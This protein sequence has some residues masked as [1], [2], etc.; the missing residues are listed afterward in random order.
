MDGFQHLSMTLLYKVTHFV[1]FI[2]HLIY[3][4]YF[5]CP[6]FILLIHTFSNLNIT[7]V[8]TFFLLDLIGL[9]NPPILISVNPESSNL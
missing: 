5:K 3:C 7:N 2:F 4:R 1:S 6:C 8:S 9:V